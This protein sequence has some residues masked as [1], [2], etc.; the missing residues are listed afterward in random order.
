MPT[1][2]SSRLPPGKA[3]APLVQA[4]NLLL[5]EGR[6]GKV[7]LGAVQ[8]IETLSPSPEQPPLL[9]HTDSVGSNSIHIPALSFVQAHHEGSC[10][11]CL[12]SCSCW[13]S[14]HTLS[15]RPC[16]GGPCSSCLGAESLGK[17]AGKWGQANVPA[18]I[19]VYNQPQTKAQ[20]LLVPALPGWWLEVLEGQAFERHKEN[21]ALGKG[22]RLLPMVVSGWSRM[23]LAPD[24][25][26]PQKPA[27]VWCRQRVPSF[28]TSS[29]AT[30]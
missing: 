14:L 4:G 22:R 2:T 16:S 30:G 29:T 19:Q 28:P 20:L 25:G 23:G 13:H 12:C 9:Q 8:P 18:P 17:V 27:A 5:E 15:P 24:V 10:V 6:D 1:I 7:P 21:T 26:M 3:P 11:F